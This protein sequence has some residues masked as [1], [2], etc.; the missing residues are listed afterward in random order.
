M[1]GQWGTLTFT[2]FRTTVDSS[3]YEHQDITLPAEVACLEV[4]SAG[5]A[6]VVPDFIHYNRR[7]HGL[8]QGTLK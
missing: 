1:D 2:D 4:G 3:R 6:D 7:F 5:V 8:T